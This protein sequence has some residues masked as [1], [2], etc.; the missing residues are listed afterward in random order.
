MLNLI[1]TIL[2]SYNAVAYTV[3][4]I[5]KNVYK[6][7]NTIIKTKDCWQEAKKNKT[8]VISENYKTIIRFSNDS[9]CVVESV[10]Q[11]D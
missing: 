6:S 7:K 8:F 1:L 10:F 3:T 9:S 2:F 4:K 11:L 5:D